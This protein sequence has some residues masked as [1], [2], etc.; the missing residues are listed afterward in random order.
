MTKG[1]FNYATLEHDGSGDNYQEW[2]I[3]HPKYGKLGKVS[4]FHPTL[5]LNKAANAHIDIRTY[6]NDMVPDHLMRSDAEMQKAHQYGNSYKMG[7]GNVKRLLRYVRTCVNKMH[8]NIRSLDSERN[9][10][11]KAA[12]KT[13]NKASVRM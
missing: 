3:M 7:T 9:T 2:H 6:T 4:L 11:M 12:S 13:K 1:E 5:D 8:P 10:G